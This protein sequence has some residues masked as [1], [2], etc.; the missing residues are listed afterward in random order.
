LKIYERSLLGSIVK[1][2]VG[3]SGFGWNKIFLP[4]GADCTLGQM[5][6]QEFRL[7]YA[8]VKPFDEM[9]QYLKEQS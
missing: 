7:W 8:K 4:K 6:E 3:D 2:P 5:D 9:A 1:K